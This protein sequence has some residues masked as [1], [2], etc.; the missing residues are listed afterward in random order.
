MTL[1]DT[2]EVH[3]CPVCQGS[4]LSC[5][6]FI[7]NQPLGAFPIMECGSCTH[8]F[9]GK[10]PGDDSL[11]RHYDELN[12]QD[13]RQTSPPGPGMRDRA[14][15]RTLRKSLPSHA[16]V[17]DVGANFG[18][19]LLSMPVTYR[20]EG[21]EA[22]G[23]S[24]PYAA[25]RGLTIYK[26]FFET[27]APSLEPGSYD[28]VI[29]LAVI[30]HIRDP[31]RFINDIRRLLRPEGISVLMTGDYA[32]WNV[33]RRGEQWHLYHGAGHLHFFSARSL[34]TLCSAAG[35]RTFRRSWAGPTPLT[36][37][38]PATLGRIL[39]CQTMSIA[40]PFL[41]GSRPMGDLLYAWSRKVD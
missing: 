20:R 35:L 16:R 21:V 23:S 10:A 41:F 6:P 26:G 28:C 33:A 39:Q 15:A 7:S 4:I 31:V 38:L 11:R 34:D 18:E 29:A 37:R 5:L 30:E 27:I 13:V 19:T 25:N 8:R 22:S 40:A 32:T 12:V 24:A 17:L 14:L 3:E 2:H 36:S 1:A 9:L